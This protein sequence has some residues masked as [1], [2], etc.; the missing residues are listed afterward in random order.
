MLSTDAADPR[1]AD[2]AAANVI[3]TLFSRTVSGMVPNYA[4]GAVAT[5]DRTEPQLGSWTVRVLRD[6]LGPRYA[7]VPALLLDP[8]AAWSDWFFKF[9]RNGGV[10]AQA[11]GLADAISLGSNDVSPKGLN[12]PHTLAAARYESGL[13]NSPQYDGDDGL[14]SGPSCPCTFNTSSSLMNLYD[15]AFTAYFALDAQE[16]AGLAAALNRT[17]VPPRMLQRAQRAIEVLN[18]GL[19]AADLGFGGSYANRLLNGSWVPR[20]APTVFSP[21]LTGAVPRG[22]LD[23]MAALLAN[24]ATFCVNASHG[25][26]GGAQGALLLNFGS[27]G[28]SSGVESCATDACVVAAVQARF[29]VTPLLQAN[30]RRA[31]AGPAAATVPLF[32]YVFGG[33]T[34]LATPAFAPPPP[35]ALTGGPEGFCF[36]APQLPGPDSTPLALWAAAPPAAAAFVTCGNAACN[37]SAAAAGLKPL[38]AMCWGGAAD[39]PQQRACAVALPSIARADPAFGDQT[40]WRGRAWAPQAFLVWLGLARYSDVASMAAARGELA[41]MA[42]GLFLRQHALFGQVNEN[43]DGVTGLGSDSVRADSYY[44][45]GALNGFIGLIEAGGYPAEVL[46]PPAP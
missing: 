17:D 34:A 14:C 5:Y 9:R 46:A 28:S 20:W 39:T 32:R 45:W 12:T 29:G 4:L 15:V 33:V 11:D 7:W 35:F 8:L 13:D 41:G 37:A 36:S 38:G 6:R 42:A 31:S 23:A 44:H 40:Y 43:L 18:D 10:L 1:A 24:P 30:I 26:T 22:R 3:T 19:Y 25:G 27:P 2:I 16:L 21:L